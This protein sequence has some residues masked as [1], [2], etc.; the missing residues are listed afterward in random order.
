MTPTVLVRVNSLKLIMI[1]DCGSK[2]T[3]EITF[4]THSCSKNALEQIFMSL[5]PSL[6]ESH[7][8]L[9]VGSRLG[10]V[11]YGAYVFS[12]AG[13]IFGIEINRELCDLQKYVIEKFG[14]N[15]R[16]AVIN[17]EM[18]TCSDVFKSADVIILNNVFE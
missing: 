5:L 9:D 14:L 16:I 18:T 3:E 6:N 13:K 12:E 17:A 8:V 11:L 15:N 10:A 7:V 1:L 2:N 4:V